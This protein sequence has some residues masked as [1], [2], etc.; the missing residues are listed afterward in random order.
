MLSDSTLQLQLNCHDIIKVQEQDPFCYLRL[1]LHL[2]KSSQICH[3]HYKGQ[4]VNFSL[5]A[6]ESAPHWLLFNSTT[7]CSQPH[8]RTATWVTLSKRKV[9]AKMLKLLWLTARIK[10]KDNRLKLHVMLISQ[11]CKQCFWGQSYY[12]S[13][14]GLNTL[15]L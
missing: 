15:L 7:C 14:N 2:Q 6:L 4:R 5:K 10:S 11:I 1:I 8:K 3:H 12:I 13:I 9:A